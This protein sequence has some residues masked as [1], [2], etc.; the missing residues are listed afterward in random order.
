MCGSHSA[1]CCALG[2]KHQRTIFLGRVGP[3]RIP[4]K[5]VRTTYVGFVFL[6]LVVSLSHVVHSGASR[7]RNIDTLFFLLGWD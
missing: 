3:V 2:A 1:L 6:H 5:C 7:V 4:Q